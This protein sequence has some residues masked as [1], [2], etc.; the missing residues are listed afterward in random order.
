[1]LPLGDGS[2][3]YVDA[4]D[5]GEVGAICLLDPRAHAGRTYELTGPRA[6]SGEDLALAIGEARG[7]PVRYVAADP[8]AVR[9]RS[10]AAGVPDWLVESG[11]RV[12][13]HA[14]LGGEATVERT[15]EA[16]TGRKP[17]TIEEFARAHV[18]AFRPG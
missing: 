14:T 15:V 16:I 6:L 9:E 18:D 8:R 1:M 3:A 2:I 4:V 17:R 12:F 5:V 10:I 7:R 11:L 13:E